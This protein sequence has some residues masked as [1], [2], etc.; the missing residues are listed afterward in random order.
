MICISEAYR[1]FRNGSVELLVLL[2]HCSR[3]TWLHARKYRAAR[4]PHAGLIP[5]TG[6]ER[7]ADFPAAVRPHPRVG[8][9]VDQRELVPHLH[10]PGHDR[11]S[12]ISGSGSGAAISLG[13]RWSSSSSRASVR[14]RR[15]SSLRSQTRPNG[16]R[17][18]LVASASSTFSP[19]SSRTIGR[20]S[21]RDA[22]R[23][24]SCSSTRPSERPARSSASCPI[25]AAA[26][27]HAAGR[28]PAV[29]PIGISP[30]V[31]TGCPSCR[32]Y[33]HVRCPDN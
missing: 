20:P 21:R 3:R 9:A 29:P 19:G 17:G 25:R 31:S 6:D 8:V 23:R 14:L 32:T 33:S 27:T 1:T 7:W 13:W 4:F 30:S 5:W 28:K 22:R 11:P 26:R 18:A 15:T 10:P 12:T 2:R 24:T 16:V